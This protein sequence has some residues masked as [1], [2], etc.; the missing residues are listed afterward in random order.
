MTRQQIQKSKKTI[1]RKLSAKQIRWIHGV[2]Q[3][4]VR[5]PRSIARTLGV[6]PST[7]RYQLGLRTGKPRFQPAPALK[8]AA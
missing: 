1:R 4:G 3:P 5:G 7:V 2:Y 6:T 8:I